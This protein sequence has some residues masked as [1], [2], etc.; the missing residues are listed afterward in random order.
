M[1]KIL[2]HATPP[3]EQVPPALY[4]LLVSNAEIDWALGSNEGAIDLEAP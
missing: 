1:A 4:D 2:P 3:L